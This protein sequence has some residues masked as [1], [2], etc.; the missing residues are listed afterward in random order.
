MPHIH[1]ESPVYLVSDVGALNYSRST[2]TRY[3][4]CQVSVVG[5][6]ISCLYC[7]SIN[8]KFLMSVAP[9]SKFG[10]SVSRPVS[11]VI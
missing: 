7:R 3:R 9:V 2:F 8:T 4:T 5:A 10:R 6:Y 11:K 1:G